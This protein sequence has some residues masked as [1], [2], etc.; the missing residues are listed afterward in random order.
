MRLCVG[1]IFC[2]FGVLKFFPS[3]CAAE[4]FA[5]RAMTELTHGLIPAPISLPLLAVLETAIGL[6]LI[7]GVMLRYAL[8]AFFIHMAGVFL[9][10]LLLPDDTWTTY[11]IAPTLEGQYVIKNIVL[12]AACLHITA[13]ELTS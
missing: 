5:V 4:T 13:K 6:A 12:V 1:T 3:A 11:G 10:L 9:S 7:T 8:A 2:W